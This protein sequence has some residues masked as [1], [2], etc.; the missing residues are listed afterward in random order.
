MSRGAR[1]PRLRTLAALLVALLPCAPVPAAGHPDFTGLWKVAD[2]QLT[3]KPEDDAAVLSDEAQR[4]RK[5]FQSQFDTQA[6]DPNQFCVPHGMPWIMLSR[7]RDYLI[8][9]YQT[10]QRVTILFEGMDWHRLIRLDQSTVPDGYTPGSNGYALAR[11]EGDALRIETTRLRATPD[12]GPYQRSEQMRVLERWRLIRHP[13]FGH[14]LEVTMEVTDPV[15]YRGHARGYQ[16]FVP[17]AAGSVINEYG[18][19]ESLFEDH[20]AK[21]RQQLQSGGSRQ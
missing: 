14:A 1:Q 4:R 8:D 10:P 5:A 21:R 9:I 12:V 20:I 16:L 3:V 13:R 17:A 6:D 15:I 11:W 2:T 7:A 18:C 19:T